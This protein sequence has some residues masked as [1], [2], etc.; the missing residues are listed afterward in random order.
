MTQKD[1]DNGKR[2][3]CIPVEGDIQWVLVDEA[4]KEHYLNARGR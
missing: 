2:W 3:L 4:V 1:Y